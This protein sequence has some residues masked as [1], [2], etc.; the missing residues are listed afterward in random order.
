MSYY[1]GELLFVP[2]RMFRIIILTIVNVYSFYD[3]LYE[4]VV[5]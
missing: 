3:N 4:S 5:N 2:I 1:S